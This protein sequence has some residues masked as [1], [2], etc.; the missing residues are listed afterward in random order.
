VAVDITAAQAE[1]KVELAVQAQQ[2]IILLSS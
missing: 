2:T 1:K